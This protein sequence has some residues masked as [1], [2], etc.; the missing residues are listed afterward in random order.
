[1][2]E[3]LST[4]TIADVPTFELALAAVNQRRQAWLGFKVVTNPDVVLDSV[5]NSGWNFN[6]SGQ[7]SADA[8]HGIFFANAAK[9]I[10][11]GREYSKRDFRQMKDITTGPHMHNTQYAGVTW[12]SLPLE[13]SGR[14]IMLG[15]G[16]V[17]A[18]L[19]AAAH[20]VDF[21]TIAVDYDS[22]YLNQQKFP[23]SE[24]VL[25]SGFDKIEGFEVRPDDYVCVMTRGHLYDTEAL[26]FAVQSPAAYVG[27]MGNPMKNENVVAAAIEQGVAA[28]ALESER[29]HA[30]IGI[31]FGGKTP[32]EI[33]LSIVAQLVQERA[34]RRK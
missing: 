26:I 17:S 30:P 11:F 20:F 15:A 21:E 27:M 25:I 4:L 12:L 2:A 32:A 19:E 29:I 3:I 8:Q 28:E 10:T 1:L 18:K 16:E 34:S 7:G 33:S 24:R 31:R 9:E 6:G 14:V 5:D 23:L 13:P 22:A